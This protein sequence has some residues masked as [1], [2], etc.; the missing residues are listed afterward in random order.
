VPA[1]SEQ[2]IIDLCT[3]IIATQD[4]DEFHAAVEALRAAL[5]R[6]IFSARDKVADLALV[7]AK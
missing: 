6:C 7:V 5:H 1:I 2:L 3:K 4:F